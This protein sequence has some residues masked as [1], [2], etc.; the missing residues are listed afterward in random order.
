MKKVAV[1]CC[2]F[3]S[4]IVSGY[5][6]IND[7]ESFT[8]STYYPSPTGVYRSLRLHPTGETPVETAGMMYYNQTENTIKFYNSTSW[9]NMS[10]AGGGGALPSGM[11][12]MFD[13]ACPSG[14]TRFAALDGVVPRGSAAYGGTG[15][16]ET[17]NHAMWYGGV[18]DVS[19]GNAGWRLSSFSAGSSWPP[20]RNV[21]WCKKN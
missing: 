8:I 18:V 9:V 15:G 7:T 21:I 16:A 11:I 12:A 2:L 4:A 6:Q 14:W 1:F 20:Y 13:A 10:S 19:T 3:L 5:A 17:H